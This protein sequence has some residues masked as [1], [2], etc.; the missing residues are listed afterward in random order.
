MR[1]VYNKLIRDQIPEIIEAAGHQPVTRVLD[2]HSYTEALLAK[3]LEEAREAQAAPVQQLA[4]ELAD[5]LEVLR[6]LASTLG[7]TWEQ[8]LDLAAAKRSQRGGFERRLLL[9]Y[10]DQP[11]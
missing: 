5:V 9:E 2:K 6:S 3:L 8:I 1:V 7:E 11:D 4:G 10:V